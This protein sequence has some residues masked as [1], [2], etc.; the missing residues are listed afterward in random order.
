VLPGLLI[1]A[2]A[3]QSAAAQEAQQAWVAQYN[4]PGS[5]WDEVTDLAV[6]E[7]CV[8]VAGFAYM[9][10]LNR[11]F[12]T[13]KYD[14]L[15]N[16]LWAR[17]YLL[18]GTNGSAQ[19]NAVAL[20]ADGN[21]F[22]TGWS[23][24]YEPGPP[25]EI[26]VD[27]ATIKYDADGNVLWVRRHRLPGHNNQPQDVVI[28]SA[29]NA[30]V[31]G[32]AWIGD[33]ENGGFDL[34]LLKYAP[35]GTLVWDRTIGKSGDRWDV[36]YSIALDPAENPV[37]AGYTQPFFFNP[38][39]DGYLVKF[40]ASGNL[41][42]ERDRESYSNGF[43]WKRVVVNAAGRIYA[44]GEIAPPGELS[45]LWTSQYSSN[46]TLLWDRHYDGTA[47]ESNFAGGMALS[48]DGG[49]V[50]NG[51]SWDINENGGLTQIATIRYEPDGTEV[52]RRL[53]RG[54]YDYAVGRDVAVDSLGRA[55]V[56][57]YGFNQN[58]ENAE[59]MVTL[60]YTPEGDL[61]WTQIYA[62][63]NGRS[64]RSTRIAVDD[65]FN[66]FV[67]G[68]AWVGF[69]NYFD[70]T[71]IR[72]DV[73]DSVETLLVRLSIPF[74]TPLSG[75]LNSLRDRD[76]NVLLVQS[77]HRPNGQEWAEILVR[78]QS[79]TLTPSR[80]DLT[81]ATSANIPG[82]TGRTWIRNFQTGRWVLL[83]TFAQGTTELV[84][85]IDD[86]AN[87]SSYVN[88]ANGQVYIRIRL[89]KLADPFTMGVNHVQVD[90]TK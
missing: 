84:R 22:V 57:G 8:V 67:A 30:Y 26:I 20:D 23:Y 70:F 18:G 90:V 68:D 21:V 11:A 79:P 82:V 4:G 54:G 5:Y 45:H 64:D 31:A 40:S 75:N 62:D 14:K 43:G 6:G 48:P 55:Y 59:D 88:P 52:W 74:G 41:L 3:A 12:A 46:G 71:T 39:I 16:Q 72:Y 24:D 42:W 69:E 25:E 2:S 29:G 33:N 73:Q 10:D 65:A 60:C 7:D 32:G 89:S 19:A 86:L 53:D 61:T 50:V 13:V 51:I 27:A 76:S 34:F 44:F 28:D 38:L 1:S 17:N 77:E 80:L 58:T 78:A 15:G 47:S 9:P 63:L 85:D 56:T 49:V 81:T 37:V 36:G 35:D 66:V 83:D 87:P